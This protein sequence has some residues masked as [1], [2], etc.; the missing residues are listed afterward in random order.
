MSANDNVF[1][2]QIPQTMSAK[3]RVLEIS[4]QSADQLPKFQ[5]NLVKFDGIKMQAGKEEYS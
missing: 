1:Q 4:Q 3:S 2:S 5:A